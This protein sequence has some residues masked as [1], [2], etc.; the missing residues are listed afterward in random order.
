[1]TSRK[2]A[3]MSEDTNIAGERLIVLILLIA[4]AYT[5]ATIQGQ[6]LNAKGYKNMSVVLKNMGVVSEN[7][8]VF[9]LVYMVKL[10]LILWSLA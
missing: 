2:V 10:G 3:R 8:A 1:M 4:I 9:I 7:T 6:K 5:S